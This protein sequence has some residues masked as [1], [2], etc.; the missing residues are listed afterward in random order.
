ML[1]KKFV[2]F[3][4]TTIYVNIVVIPLMSNLYMIYLNQRV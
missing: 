3:I 2:L 4:S 1:G